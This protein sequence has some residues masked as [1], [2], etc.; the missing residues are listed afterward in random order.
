MNSTQQFLG[1]P[2]H[3][4]DAQVH[5]SA[6][7]ALFGGWRVYV[8][9]NRDAIAQHVSP[10]TQEKRY[11]LTF[12]ETELKSLLNTCI[13][14]DLLTVEP[15]KRPGHPDETMIQIT[16]INPQKESRTA[17]KW[18]GDQHAAF[19]AVSRILFEL[20]TRTLELT[21]Y[22]TGPFDW[23]ASPIDSP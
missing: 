6:M 10:V 21:P 17:S 15:S 13:E 8:F 3:W 9:G 12:T 16:L 5:L 20:T 4:K 18:A 14:N 7:Q 1:D 22:H 19:D 2:A 23:S 11:R